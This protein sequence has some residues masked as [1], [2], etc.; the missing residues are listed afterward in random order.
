MRDNFLINTTLLT[1]AGMNDNLD[2]L[3]LFLSQIGDN[4]LNFS[5]CKC[6]KLKKKLE[7][8]SSIYYIN[9]SVFLEC[10]SLKSIVIL[11]SVKKMETIHSKSL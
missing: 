1:A 9:N 11:K 8:P 4:L 7:I 6:K 5:F 10:I 2:I 3:N